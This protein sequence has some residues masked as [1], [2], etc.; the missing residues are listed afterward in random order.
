MK[1][2]ERIKKQKS[3][4]KY[5]G[6]R[7]E[8]EQEVHKHQRH[9]QHQQEKETEMA[10][11]SCHRK[12]PLNLFRNISNSE[13]SFE[14]DIYGNIRGLL[15]EGA[16]AKV[17]H[18]FSF[19]INTCIAL[20]YFFPNFV[21]EYTEEVNFYKE[22]M[23]QSG[24]N[25]QNIIHQFNH[26]DEKLEIA[27]EI[28]DMDLKG[29][30]EIKRSNYNESEFLFEVFNQT[31][32]LLFAI[33]NI[34]EVAVHMDLKPQNIMMIN[35]IPKI[36]DFGF[37][38]IKRWIKKGEDFQ[39]GT[40]QFM[41]PELANF[42]HDIKNVATKPDIWALGVVIFQMLFGFDQYPYSVMDGMLQQIVYLTRHKPDKVDYTNVFGKLEQYRKTNKYLVERIMGIIERCLNTNPYE[43]PEA[44]E[45][46]EQLSQS[47]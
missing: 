7:G 40:F 19:K 17:Y 1:A 9:Q 43:R 47:Y 15:G 28:A 11:C 10:T 37:S 24:E 44:E 45:L 16:T 22:F 42:D 38:K 46:Y 27:M 23:K 6:E 3:E 5:L 2:R 31:A 13:Y 20:K 29:Y 8:G 21:N 41:S 12:I 32:Y 30:I 36:A 39:Y 25:I 4:V 14:F 33:S 34:H 35:G 26:N 18:A